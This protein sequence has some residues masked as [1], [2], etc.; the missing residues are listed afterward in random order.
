MTLGHNI[1]DSIRAFMVEEIDMDIASDKIYRSVEMTQIGQGR[2]PD[3]LRAAALNGTDDTLAKSLGGLFN[4]FTQR[5]RSRGFGVHTVR[6][7]HDAANVLTEDQ[8]NRYFCRGLAR[9]AETAAISRLE[10]YRAKCV[11]NPRPESQAKIGLLVEPTVILI[12]LRNHQ[13]IEP[14]LGI[15]AGF[16][17][18]ISL[19]I[20]AKP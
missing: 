14:A 8:F 16:G 6:V 2:F 13:G 15:P 3:L 4:Q 11:L 9:H 18:G 1:T 7:R 12:D 17:S 20:P 19:R 10:V 5:K